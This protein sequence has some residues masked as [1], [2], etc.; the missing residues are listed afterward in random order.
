MRSWSV[1]KVTVS[2]WHVYTSIRPAKEELV[3][4]GLK[5]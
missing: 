1:H 2:K 5:K 3:D 4:T